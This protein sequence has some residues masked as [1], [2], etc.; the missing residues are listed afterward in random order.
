MNMITSKQ[1][2]KIKALAAL[3]AKPNDELV[4]EGQHLIEMALASNL[5][6][7][8]LTV[9]P[10]PYAVPTTLITP[11][12][13][14]KLSDK[15]TT[16]GAFAL[17][18]KPNLSLDKNKHLLYLDEVSDPG[19]MG[20]ILRT[21]L[22][23]NFGGVLLSPRCVNVYNE[24]VLSSAQGA[25]FLLPLKKATLTDLISLKKEGYKV[26]VTTLAKA[27]PIE[28]VPNDKLILVLGNEARGVSKPIFDVAD[29]LVKINIRHIDS[30]NVAIAGA[31]LMYEISKRS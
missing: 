10:L 21:A 5:V 20:T 18:K 30:L 27:V 22:A 17:I 1:N 6:M 7:E 14:K 15:V 24:K 29:Y 23:F 26:V 2:P 31:I 25:H 16:D 9:N 4:I 12:I 3:K 8:L 11:E 28:A 19:N 13:A